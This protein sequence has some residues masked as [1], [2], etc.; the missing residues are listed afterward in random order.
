MVAVLDEADVTDLLKP[1]EAAYFR[2]S[3]RCRARG[4]RDADAQRAAFSMIT[5][6]KYAYRRFFFRDHGNEFG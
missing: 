2:H 4:D 1:D 3:G 6:E 5:K